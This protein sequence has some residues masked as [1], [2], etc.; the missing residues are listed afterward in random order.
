MDSKEPV[1]H[2]PINPK[3]EVIPNTLTINLVTQLSTTANA[4]F[5]RFVSDFSKRIDD[6]ANELFG[7]QSSIRPKSE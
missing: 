3:I 2:A 7:P 1:G 5:D 6:K 4:S